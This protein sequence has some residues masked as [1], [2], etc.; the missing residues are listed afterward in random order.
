M[1]PSIWQ[2][3]LFGGMRERQM[4]DIVAQR[5]HPK[6]PSPISN[7]IGI[8]QGREPCPDIVSRIL[9]DD[10]EHPPGELHHPQRVLK[11]L[12]GSSRVAQIRHASWWMWRSLWNALELRTS[13]S[14]LSSLTNTW[15]GSRISW[16]SLGIGEP[17]FSRLPL[18]WPEARSVSFDRKLAQSSRPSDEWA[19]A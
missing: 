6:N 17:Q 18:I 16:M 14:W 7:L 9:G 11:A 8:L 13:R 10:V 3:L 15:I 12:V 2:K 19:Q 5:R 1:I 4:P